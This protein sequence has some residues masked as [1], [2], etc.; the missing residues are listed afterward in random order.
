MSTNYFGTKLTAMQPREIYDDPPSYPTLKCCTWRYHQA[1]NT[2]LQ[3][4]LE[5]YYLGKYVDVCKQMGC[6]IAITSLHEKVSDNENDSQGSTMTWKRME[7]SPTGLTH[8][9]TQWIVA[10]DQAMNTV[11]YDDIPGCTKIRASILEMWQKEFLKLK[12]ELEVKDYLIFG[13]SILL[14]SSAEFELGSL[15][16]GPLNAITAAVYLKQ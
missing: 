7:F 3:L 16:M 5:K 9:I 1:S 13:V 12:T 2:T 11:E 8:H 14:S 10:D 6:T 4:H 15:N